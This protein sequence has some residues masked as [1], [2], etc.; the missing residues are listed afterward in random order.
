MAAEIFNKNKLGDFANVFS[1]VGIYTRHIGE[2]VLQHIA[3]DAFIGLDVFRCHLKCLVVHALTVKPHVI[4]VCT[5]V[6]NDFQPISRCLVTAEAH[7]RSPLPRLM[8][9]WLPVIA[10]NL[11]PPICRSMIVAT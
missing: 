10:T 4:E 1:K 11:R 6:I 3:I 5:L 2:D 7:A 9:S 8:K